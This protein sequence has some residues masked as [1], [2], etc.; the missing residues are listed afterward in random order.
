VNAGDP[1]DHTPPQIAVGLLG[2]RQTRASVLA[3]GLGIRFTCSETCR[4]DTMLW[5]GRS[6]ARALGIKL[7]R[8]RTLVA[9]VASSRTGVG[10]GRFRMHLR[11]WLAKRLRGGRPVTLTLEV[12]GHDAN[13]N[14][15]IGWYRVTMR[16]RTVRLR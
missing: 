10:A 1:N 5:I 12:I 3:K 7:A 6:T 8:T 11:S 2:T 15:T 14:R 16:G 9:R 13:S 4:L